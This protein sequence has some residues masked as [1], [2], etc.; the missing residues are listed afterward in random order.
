MRTSRSSNGVLTWQSKWRSNYYETEQQSS[1]NGTRMI[2]RASRPAFVAVRSVGRA[3]VFYRTAGL[4]ATLASQRSTAAMGLF[5]PGFGKKGAPQGPTSCAPGAP[6]IGQ[7]C[8][9]WGGEGLLMTSPKVS[10]KTAMCIQ[11]Q[12]QA[13]TL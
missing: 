13:T 9:L 5:P 1:P 7:Y 3:A 11:T 6:L 8:L 10:P 2:R 4:R 12:Q